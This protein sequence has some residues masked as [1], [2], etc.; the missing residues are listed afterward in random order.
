MLLI[1]VLRST[2]KMDALKYFI[3]VKN[4]KFTIFER[5]TL[6][7]LNDLSRVHSAS[8]LRPSL[9]VPKS[10]FFSLDPDTLELQK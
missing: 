6:V 9:L 1:S 10:M 7:S 4:I 8:R 5:A 2:V 3:N